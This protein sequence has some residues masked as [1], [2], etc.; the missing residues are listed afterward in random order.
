[1]FRIKRLH[2]ENYT[3]Y[4]QATIEFPPA[5]LFFIKGINYDNGENSAIESGKTFLL[6]SI[7][8]CLFGR[9]IRNLTLADYI[10]WGESNFYL[11]LELYNGMKVCRTIDSLEVILPDGKVV[12]S[13]KKTAVQNAINTELAIDFKTFF[14]S[15]YT[16]YLFPSFVTLTAS[17]RLNLFTALFGLSVLDNCSKFASKEAGKLF[18]MANKYD[19]DISYIQGQ[20]KELSNSYE[21]DI[22]KWE[23][24]RDLQ[25]AGLEERKK[26]VEEKLKE[27]RK[28]RTDKIIFVDKFIDKERK[29]L[30]QLRTEKEKIE[31]KV[32][33]LESE[34]KNLDFLKKHKKREISELKSALSKFDKQKCPVCL[35]PITNSSHFVNS[36]KERIEKAEKEHSDYVEK[37]K[38]LEEDLLVAKNE[39]HKINSVIE[40]HLKRRELVLQYESD[41]KR[42]DYY[43]DDL[44]R[45][46]KTINENINELKSK[47]NPYEQLEKVRRRKLENLQK[48]LQQKIEKKNLVKEKAEL[49]QFW[50]NGFKSIKANMFKSL[51][52]S[53]ENLFNSYLNLLGSNNAVK[54]VKEGEKLDFEFYINGNLSKLDS[55]SG[56]GKQILRLACFFALSTLLKNKISGKFP[57]FFILDEPMVNL[58]IKERKLVMDYLY[59][60]KDN[61]Q[62]FLV[63]HALDIND[64]NFD[65]VFIVEKRKGV[66]NVREVR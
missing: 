32:V 26:E 35:Q 5:G 65:K 55:F 60:L 62:I 33:E 29:D 30:E 1:M 17:E 10:R 46:L 58:S 4:K 8:F 21:S 52:E 64:S 38:Q 44:K 7:A 9:T 12:S 2:L 45:E 41:I 34:I 39:L 13:D 37:I 51:K 20:I 48:S 50:T 56:G 49:Y 63:D 19:L 31:L 27:L 22:T 42:L 36:L 57:E 6:E 53:F 16:G 59:S 23:K 40:K 15:V 43:I 24:E 47:K 18:Q 66:S 28:L 25:I 14:F 54:L 3:S 11:E 61:K